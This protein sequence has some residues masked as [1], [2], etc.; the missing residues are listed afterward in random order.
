M[1]MTE[2]E[3]IRVV[4]YCSLNG[5]GEGGGEI[6]SRKRELSEISV[7]ASTKIT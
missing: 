5:K 6:G 1:H 2:L 4:S 7:R 3:F